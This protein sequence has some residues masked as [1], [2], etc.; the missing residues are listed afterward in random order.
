MA[1]T[2]TDGCP[3]KDR[4]PATQ[5]YLVLCSVASIHD[6]LLSAIPGIEFHKGIPIQIDSFTFFNKSVNDLI[7]L[8]D[9]MIEVRDDP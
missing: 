5:N 9:M 2:F 7:I 1:G 3:T 8:D 6:E 4:S